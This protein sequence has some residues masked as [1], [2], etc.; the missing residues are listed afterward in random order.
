MSVSTT[1]GEINLENA[2]CFEVSLETVSG[3]IKTSDVSANDFSLESVSGD[4]VLSGSFSDIDAE[5]VSGDFEFVS[6][7]CPGKID[8]STV[9]GSIKVTIPENDGFTASLD[10]VSG[11]L[12]CDFEAV[13]SKKQVRYG[14]G[15]AEFDFETVSGDASIHKEITA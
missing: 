7:S 10:T 8:C 5:S 4:C 6:S 14:D 11:D 15:S 3:R 13:F 12:E 1:S 9:S 2:E